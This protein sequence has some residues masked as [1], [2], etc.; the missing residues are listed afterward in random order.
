MIFLEGSSRAF[1]GKRPEWTLDGALVGNDSKP[2]WHINQRPFHWADGVW[3]AEV[4]ATA[5]DHHLADDLRRVIVRIAPDTMRRW[6][7]VGINP[8]LEACAQLRDH[9]R[10]KAF[11][12]EMTLLTLL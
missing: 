6:K 7:E 4:V 5:S 11:P 8:F 9:L 1:L 12:G 3:E 2:Q 10:R